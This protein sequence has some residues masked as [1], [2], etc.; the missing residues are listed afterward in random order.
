V[1]NKPWDEAY[2]DCRKSYHAGWLISNSGTV[3]AMKK[4]PADPWNLAR[5]GAGWGECSE[6][7]GGKYPLVRGVSVTVVSGAMGGYGH[8]ESGAGDYT[9]SC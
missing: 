4:C 5:R 3:E 2:R 8:S 7:C 9:A 6:G 1:K